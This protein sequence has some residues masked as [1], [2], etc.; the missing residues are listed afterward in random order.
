MSEIGASNLESG[1]LMAFFFIAFAFTW[2]F[3]IPDALSKMEII[4]A[5]LLTGLG[6]LGAFGPLVSAI[7]VT[8]K[9]DGQAGLTALFR[10][11]VDCRFKKR[12]WL[13]ILVFFPLLVTA[14]FLIAIAVDGVIPPSVVFSE[15]WILFAAFFSVLF[16]SG[17]FE[18]NSDGAVTRFPVCRPGSVLLHLA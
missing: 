15:P 5:S 8:A 6:F 1:R 10:K 3:W 16:L 7:I 9:F 17:P 13:S 2:F 11:A 18:E 12:W 14:A 4:P